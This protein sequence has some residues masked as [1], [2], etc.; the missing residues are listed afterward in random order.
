ME[1]AQPL[2]RLYS[3]GRWGLSVTLMVG[4]GLAFLYRD[5]V[6]ADAAQQYVDSLGF[7]AG[8]GFVGLYA[9]AALLL[10]P[11]FPL[12]LAAGALFGPVQGTVLNL[13]GATAGATAAFKVSRYLVGDWARGLASGRLES[14]VRGVESSDWQYV[15]LMRLVPVVPYILLNYALGLTRIRWSRYVL[16]SFFAMIPAAAICAVTGYAGR[17]ILL[18]IDG[19]WAIVVPCLG[20]AA[21]VVVGWWLT[22]GD[23]S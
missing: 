8:P 16:A 23:G 4:I 18:D 3:I 22:G 14:I 7:W 9:V 13:L 21:T 17:R 20:V 2:D 12:T 15:A 19:P 1:T 5:T 10:I 6:S 11:C